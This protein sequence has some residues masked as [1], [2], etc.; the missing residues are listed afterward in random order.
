MI[1]DQF[2]VLHD[3]NGVFVDHSSAA[4]DF[5][6]DSFTIDDLNKD[7]D[8]VYVGLYKPFSSL[9][10]SF[11]TAN[12]NAG[13]LAFE[14]YDKNDAAFKSLTVEDETQGS[15]R[16]GF[17]FW[18]LPEDNNGNNIWE[19][20]T[21]KDIELFWIR[22]RPSVTHSSTE[23]QGLNILF[24][25][26]QDLIEE[27]FNIVSKHAV[28]ADVTSWV[29][30]HQATVKDIVQNIRNQ[31]NKKFSFNKQKRNLGHL[32]AKNITR[33]DFIDIGEIRQAAKYK[34]LSRIYL[35]EISD[36][37]E[38]K[39]AALGRKH[40]KSFTKAM[41]LFFLTIDV[42]DDGELDN[43]ESASETFTQLVIS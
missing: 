15:T 35:D 29:L 3:N 28:A 26:D 17:A 37:P 27:R 23:Y 40:E 33:F 11:V 22:F 31:G 8:Y 34:T 38:D 5:G 41:D 18:N 6:R 13:T 25:N 16:S 19:L 9:F 7:E 10:S 14:Y 1:A 12:L 21:I 24:S 43:D 20:T 39:W 32:I 4:K 30:K 2:T 42:D 36:S